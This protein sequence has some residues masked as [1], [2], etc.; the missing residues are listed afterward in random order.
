MHSV[1]ISIVI[2]TLNRREL[3]TQTL[4][5]VQAQTF[6]FWEALVVDDGSTD[7]T[8]EYVSELHR[9]DT[10]IHYLLRDRHHS[11][12][13][14][15][16]NQGTASAQGEYIIFLD[17]D[18]C[19]APHALDNRFQIM[20]AHP[21]L[22]FAVFGCIL[23]GD[24]PGDTPL[25]WNGDTGEDDINRFLANDVPW[26][27]TSPIW[28]KKALDKLG[29]WDET[30]TTGQDWD[31]HLRALILN[32]NYQRFQP[33]DCYWRKP[34]GQ[35]IG[36]QSAAREYLACREKLL[37]LAHERLE[38]AGLLTLERKKILRKR[39]FRLADS[40]IY[41]GEN[42]QAFQVWQRCYER[43]LSDDFLY[44][45]GLRYLQIIA[46]LPSGLKRIGRKLIREFGNSAVVFHWPKGFRN[47]PFVT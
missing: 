43:Q 3:L 9:Q 11:G 34:H 45:Q 47:T 30:L 29:P 39:Y 12:A 37:E 4:A 40:W 26:Q 32:L 38:A 23:F 6:E 16:R 15:C 20:K 17:S 33:P 44:T 8:K 31:Q 18:D 46:A 28:R 7:G 5:S 42:H 21:E 14:A 13:P 35:T 10:R 24:R 1:K 36:S 25:L 2:P 22:D 27:T 19:L 41:A